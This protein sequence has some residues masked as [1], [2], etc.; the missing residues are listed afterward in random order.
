MLCLFISGFFYFWNLWQGKFVQNPTHIA[1]ALPWLILGAITVITVLSLVVKK[2]PEKTQSRLVYFL[3]L[4]LLLYIVAEAGLMGVNS[5]KKATPD[6]YSSLT[7]TQSNQQANQP[8]V[9]LIVFDEYMG[10]NGLKAA[11]NYDN[12]AQDS[13]LLQN[14]FH[15][16]HNSRSNYDLTLFS[17]ASL[18]NSSY[19]PAGNRQ[20]AVGVKQMHHSFDRIYNNRVQDIFK[21][22]GYSIN[23]YSMFEMRSAP[24]LPYSQV[25]F[26]PINRR[27]ITENTF[28]DMVI[29]HFKISFDGGFHFAHRDTHFSLFH[30]NEQLAADLAEN[31]AQPQKQPGFYYV[32]FY[33]PHEP[34]YFDKNGQLLSAD[35]SWAVSD[36]SLP[37]FYTYNLEYANRKMQMVVNAILAHKKDNA[38]IIL[39]GDHGY[40]NNSITKESPLRCANLNAVYFPD[41]NYNGLYDTIT[42]VNII[43]L[44]MNKAL[45]TNYPLL[46][47]S[48]T[49]L[50]Q[51][52]PEG[53][54]E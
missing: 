20:N 33:T 3:N 37:Q 44:A 13:F 1:G 23:N 16:Q 25:N 2:L 4:L 40:R 10:T 19:F 31:A 9:Y 42:N 32:H 39:L 36:I 54:L 12:S 18:L 8:D 28:Y 38:I 51:Q 11:L 26:F 21:A 14:G 7:A 6:V 17:T 47:D 27:L 15:I 22:H 43:R 46:P 45:G 34:F 49:L 24:P 52:E 29:S 5:F 41:H 53:V 30:Y 35:S 50:K 48:S